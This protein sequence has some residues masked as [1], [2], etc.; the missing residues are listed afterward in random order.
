MLGQ[1]DGDVDDHV[2]L[3]TDVA[4]LADALRA[5]GTEPLLRIYSEASSPE[6]VRDILRYGSDVEVVRPAS[7]RQLVQDELAATLSQYRITD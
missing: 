4:G 1:L 2:L 5:S 3:A 7:L 6:L